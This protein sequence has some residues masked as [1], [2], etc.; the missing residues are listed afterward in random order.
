MGFEWDIKIWNNGKQDGW[1]TARAPSYGMSYFDRTDLPY[2]F[3]LADEFTV[4]DQYFQSTFTATDPNR[5]HQ[6]SGTNGLSINANITDF[7]GT[8]VVDDS[9]KGKM[10]WT[11]VGELLE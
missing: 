7:F 9:Q 10:N 11:T 2:Y 1:D 4:G 6:F 8:G 3:A 5:L